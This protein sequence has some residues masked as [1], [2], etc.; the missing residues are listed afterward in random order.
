MVY[1][2]TGY[3]KEG[4]IVSLDFGV[5]YKGFQ[6]DAALTVGVGKISPEARKL[7]E[8][9]EASLIAGYSM[10]PAMG[11]PW[12]ISGQPYRAMLSTGVTAWS[13]NIPVTGSAG[14]CTRTRWYRTSAAK[15]KA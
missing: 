7:M 8:V 4:D 6:G 10:L 11:V 3:L 12:V 13:G 9:T 2:A 14:I 5:I 15:A 1:L